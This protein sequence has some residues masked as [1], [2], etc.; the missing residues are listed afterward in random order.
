MIF[1]I[2]DKALLERTIKRKS[3]ETVIFRNAEMAESVRLPLL[4]QLSL[5]M[6]RCRMMI[7]L[8]DGDLSSLPNNIEILTS[9]LE[10]SDPNLYIKY[11]GMLDD[12]SCR[13]EEKYLVL[14]NRLLTHVPDFSAAMGNVMF[15]LS[16][17]DLFTDGEIMNIVK[18][19]NMMDRLSYVFS[20]LTN[21]EGLNFNKAYEYTSFCSEEC[22]MMLKIHTGKHVSFEEISTHM[23]WSKYVDR[24]SFLEIS[25]SCMVDSE[26]AL[27]ESFDNGWDRRMQVYLGR[28]ICD[29]VFGSP[30]TEEKISCASGIRIH[31]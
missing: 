4:K 24:K 29:Q 17:K 5:D 20:K 1:D 22:S 26:K 21:A 2:E 12:H 6:F 14:F 27:W 3:M 15:L 31:G 16:R 18:V 10:A 28:A 23:D 30:T 9:G 8:A 13:D 19:R 7:D 25:D 11:M